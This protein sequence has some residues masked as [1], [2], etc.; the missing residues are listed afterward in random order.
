MNSTRPSRARS[1]TLDPAKPGAPPHLQA[2]PCA[3]FLDVD[4]TLLPLS[5]HPREVHVPS[6]LLEILKSLR[7]RSFGALA[8][9][10]G[11]SL[12]ALDA[13]FTPERFA[14]AGQ[15][16]AER[17]D[18][19]GELHVD[20]AHTGALGQIRPLVLELASGIPGSFIED[21]KLSIAIH[22][23]D[24][25][26]ALAG[27]HERLAEVLCPYPALGLLK[28]KAVL[29]I[30]A[31]LAEK[32]RALRA[33]LEEPPFRGRLPV[34]LGDDVTDESAFETV[35]RAGGVSIKVGAGLSC[36]RFRLTSPAKAVSWLARQ[37]RTQDGS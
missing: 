30:R 35:N 12:A 18:A 7:D 9:V 37:T 31:R 13:C 6:P 34:C 4:G 24:A 5:A 33:F 21:K 14:L 23:R 28:G 20:C 27:L 22:I 3:F 16:G 11:R 25:P 8:L 1:V 2:V 15:H 36:A 32:G 26:G 19:A 29:E 10:S 17:R